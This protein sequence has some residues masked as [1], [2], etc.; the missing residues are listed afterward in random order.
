MQKVTEQLRLSKIST[1]GQNFSLYSYKV[2]VEPPET[3][4]SLCFTFLTPLDPLKREI[5][6][7]ERILAP[8][9]N[10][11]GFWSQIKAFF[12]YKPFATYN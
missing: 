1:N 12:S 2:L 11:T 10:T 3:E 7:L 5:E 6:N 4:T 8:F 9:C